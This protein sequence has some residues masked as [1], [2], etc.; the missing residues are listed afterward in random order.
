MN[1]SRETYPQD[2]RLAVEDFY[3]NSPASGSAVFDLGS[4]C[5]CEFDVFRSSPLAL[6]LSNDYDHT[7][8]FMSDKIK[9]DC[10]PIV[11]RY[12]GIW[13][14][15][16]GDSAEFVIPD[17]AAASKCS[18]ELLFW[19][20]S[21][22][23]E[24]VKD[25]VLASKIA[26]SGQG[27]N[28]RDIDD[29]R[30]LIE[31]VKD[32]GIEQLSKGKR[33]FKEDYE[34]L[35]SSLDMQISQVM[36]ERRGRIPGRVGVA[37]GN[38]ELHVTK[39]TIGNDD[40]S[41]IEIDKQILGYAKVILARLLDKVGPLGGKKDKISIASSQHLTV[42]PNEILFDGGQSGPHP[43]EQ[44]VYG[45]DIIY[46][47]IIG[48]DYYLDHTFYGK[49]E[50]NSLAALK[51]DYYAKEI[52]DTHR[53]LQSV[54]DKYRDASKP[55]ITLNHEE[56]RDRYKNGRSKMVAHL[57][58][59]TIDS[60][61]SLYAET[62]D[63]AKTIAGI[64]GG[65][66]P[67]LD[68]LNP[69][70]DTSLRRF[71]KELE[72]SRK[73]MVTT[74]LLYSNGGSLVRANSDTAVWP[75]R[76]LQPLVNDSRIANERAAAMWAL[77]QYEELVSLRIHEIIEYQRAPLGDLIE[78][79]QT[80]AL[81]VLIVRLAARYIHYASHRSWKPAEQTIEGALEQ[82]KAENTDLFGASEMERD[83]YVGFVF[84]AFERAVKGID[85]GLDE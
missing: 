76:R 58:A 36:E 49:V 21:V 65:S 18:I 33:V 67:V 85:V 74:G 48:L 63:I 27:A 38:A 44:N 46:Y 11:E 26:N 82:V 83:K 31:E 68:F 24:F 16:H 8:V 59:A 52:E 17:L 79:D 29:V 34:K 39:S 41:L 3:R 45:T 4:T 60:A 15:S 84:S 50:E 70:K 69:D 61:T 10:L 66:N 14:S 28:S 30:T 7:L 5:V 22:L 81:K 56:S 25:T 42:F 37:Y 20:D 77:E 6:L 57:I 62:L 71:I 23:S 80:R 47:N 1:F 73:Q 72:E 9:N 32:V 40:N 55:W 19:A 54:Q 53:W 43:I 13:I 78:K 35:Y 12:G 75:T 51:K 2:L 64:K